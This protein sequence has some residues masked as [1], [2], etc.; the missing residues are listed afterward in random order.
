MLSKLRK[1]ILD[2]RSPQ[3]RRRYEGDE[4]RSRMTRIYPG[5]YCKPNGKYCKKCK[6]SLVCMTQEAPRS[7]L[8]CAQCNVRFGSFYKND[9][10]SAL[11][12][13]GKHNASNYST[14]RGIQRCP[15]R[16][17]T[18]VNSCP[19]CNKNHLGFSRKV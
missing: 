13:G 17:A 10:S 2:A 11:I 3:K 9:G 18:L 7:I 6:G 1:K 14:V 8:R 19:A 16:K 15:D 12:T 4:R 5:Y